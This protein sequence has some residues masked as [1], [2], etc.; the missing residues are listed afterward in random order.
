MT[1]FEVPVALAR[2]VVSVAHYHL[3]MAL[4]VPENSM[5]DRIGVG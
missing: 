4:W 2:R 3:S 5:K 1:R